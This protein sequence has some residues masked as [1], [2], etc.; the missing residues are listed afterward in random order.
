MA[1]VGP[2]SNAFTVRVGPIYPGGGQVIVG[3]EKFGG[4]VPCY[5]DF[6]LDKCNN[7]GLSRED[8]DEPMNATNAAMNYGDGYQEAVADFV[9]RLPRALEMT[10]DPALAWLNLWKFDKQ[11]ENPWPELAGQLIDRLNDEAGLADAFAAAR[12]SWDAVRGEKA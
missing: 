2:P 8:R 6:H 1:N 10:I 9:K 5:S 12:A 11:D 7:C 4:I 3:T